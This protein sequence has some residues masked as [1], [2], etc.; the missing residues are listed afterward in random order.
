MSDSLIQGLRQ[1][2]QAIA[3]IGLGYTGWPLAMAL[4]GHFEVRGYDSS[5]IRIELLKKEWASK[6]KNSNGKV[7]SDPHLQGQIIG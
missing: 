1:G 7:T 3:I 2:K 5:A 6:E 4:S